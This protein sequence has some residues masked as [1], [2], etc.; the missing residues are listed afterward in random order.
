MLYSVYFKRKLGGTI[1][2]GYSMGETTS[3]EY[4]GRKYFLEVLSVD[5]VEGR[6]RVDVTS[7][8]N[9]K[10]SKHKTRELGVH[11]ISLEGSMLG[12]VLNNA[13]HEVDGDFFKENPNAENELEGLKWG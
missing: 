10:G 6:A 8:D 12:D 2:V 5:E 7:T 11:S 4:K 3:G 1:T 9:I 13:V